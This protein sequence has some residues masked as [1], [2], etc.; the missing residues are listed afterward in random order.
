VTF[1]PCSGDAYGALGRSEDIQI[2][3]SKDIYVPG[4]NTPLSGDPDDV[5]FVGQFI[6]IRSNG[7]Y[8]DVTGSIDATDR[9]AGD[10]IFNRGTYYYDSLQFTVEYPSTGDGDSTVITIS[11]VNKSVDFWESETWYSVQLDTLLHSVEGLDLTS[12]PNV[13]PSYLSDCTEGNYWAYFMAEDSR[14]PICVFY[15]DEPNYFDY[16]EDLGIS[17][18]DP[19]LHTADP[20]LD[21]NVNVADT[22]NIRVT[23]DEWTQLGFSDFKDLTATAAAD[24]A[25]ALRRYF[26][27]YEVNGTTLTPISF[28]V[29]YFTLDSALDIA[30]FYIDP[31]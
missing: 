19:S 16:Y 21:G 5:N 30:D 31:Y 17:N 22:S 6:Q 8:P 15:E 24:D 4:S 12:V 1:S 28:D 20:L 9:D 7:V 23:I 27:L 2:C 11:P 25:N 18:D 10:F 26:A 29:K 3:V 13:T 14:H